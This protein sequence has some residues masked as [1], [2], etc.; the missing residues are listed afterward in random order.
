MYDFK[1]VKKSSANFEKL[2]IK[3]LLEVN[4]NKY[5][6]VSITM[7]VGKHLTCGNFNWKST[8]PTS[9]LKIISE[10]HIHVFLLDCVSC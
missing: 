5:Q 1:H 4:R 7:C 8:A 3:P 6:C 9:G 2:I 10:S